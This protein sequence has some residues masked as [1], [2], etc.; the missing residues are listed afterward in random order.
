[1]NWGTGT[2][3]QEDASGRPEGAA[4]N[5]RSGLTAPQGREL[6]QVVEELVHILAAPEHVGAAERERV[7]GHARAV[8]QA[9]APYLGTEDGR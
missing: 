5:C 7:L 1:M 8:L 2:T 6:R 4:P 3:R 9:T